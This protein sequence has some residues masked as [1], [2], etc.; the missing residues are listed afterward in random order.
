MTETEFNNLIDALFNRIEETLEAAEVDADMDSSNGVLT[1][2]FENDTTMVFSRQVAT[3]QLW[4]AARSGGYH[5]QYDA[6]Q[7]DWSCTRSGRLFCRA[8]EEELQQQAGISIAFS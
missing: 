5:F 7:G 4:L 1:I 6:D 2:E 8:L 3:C